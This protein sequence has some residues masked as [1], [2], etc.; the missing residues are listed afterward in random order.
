MFCFVC[1][2]ININLK[3]TI[4]AQF[5]KRFVKA[6]NS[7]KRKIYYPP[8]LSHQLFANSV[9]KFLLFSFS[10]YFIYFQ[11]NINWLLVVNLLLCIPFALSIY[12]FAI[13]NKCNKIHFTKTFQKQ[14]QFNV[15]VVSLPL[16]QVLLTCET[17]IES[18]E[19]SNGNKK[20]VEYLSNSHRAD[21]N[22]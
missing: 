4:Y 10:S 5:V 15:V 9:L 13:F 11:L 22:K 21:K 16:L 7:N 17:L 3:S 14:L 2:Q 1:C 20:K 6:R 19:Q 12:L 18:Y 8:N